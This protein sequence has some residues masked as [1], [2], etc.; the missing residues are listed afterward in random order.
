M[1]TLDMEATEDLM[2]HIGAATSLTSLKIMAL[3]YRPGM[4]CSHAQICRH[5]TGLQQLRELQLSYDGG[6]GCSR[7]ALHLTALTGKPTDHMS[8]AERRLSCHSLWLLFEGR[9]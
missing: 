5:L 1:K 4:L 2:Q 8:A 9:A 6:R 3:L 7:D